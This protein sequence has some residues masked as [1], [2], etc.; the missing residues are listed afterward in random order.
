MALKRLFA[1]HTPAAHKLGIWPIRTQSAMLVAPEVLDVPAVQL[2]GSPWA[3]RE[4]GENGNQEYRHS[5]GGHG[6]RR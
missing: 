6:E 5:L 1:E 4:K 3:G 2:G